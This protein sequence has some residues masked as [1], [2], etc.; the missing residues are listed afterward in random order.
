MKTAEYYREHFELPF[1][2]H[3]L[4]DK[5]DISQIKEV[6]VLLLRRESMDRSCPDLGRHTVPECHGTL[7]DG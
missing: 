1:F 3:F 7:F 4:K 5:G 6:N 2:N